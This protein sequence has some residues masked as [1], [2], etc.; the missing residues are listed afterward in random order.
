M[1]N[2]YLV[3]TAFTKPRD[4]GV[5]CCNTIMFFSFIDNNDGCGLSSSSLGG[6]LDIPLVG[7]TN[8]AST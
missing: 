1:T 6:V 2:Y 4:N 8:I 5:I 3:S 7:V